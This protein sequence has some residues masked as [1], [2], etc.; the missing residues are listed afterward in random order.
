MPLKPLSPWNR[1]RTD[2]RLPVRLTGGERYIPVAVKHVARAKSS[3]GLVI[4]FSK[5]YGM[6]GWSVVWALTFSLG[7]HTHTDISICGS[8]QWQHLRQGNR[9]LNRNLVAFPSRMDGHMRFYADFVLSRLCCVSLLFADFYCSTLALSGFLSCV[10]FTYPLELI[11][12][13]PNC[14]QTGEWVAQLVW[15]G[16]KR[17]SLGQVMFHAGDNLYGMSF[18]SGRYT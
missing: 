9:Y 14:N 15:R 12:F 6:V 18:R 1:N 16:V 7:E 11:P 13:Y 10:G 2:T 3:V 8:G 5:V 17:N 4:C